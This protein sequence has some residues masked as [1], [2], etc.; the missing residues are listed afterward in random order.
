ME[1][2]RFARSL[3]ARKNGSCVRRQKWM[4]SLDFMALARWGHFSTGHH[5]ATFRASVH[6]ECDDI[7]TEVCIARIPPA[8][9]LDLHD[10]RSSPQK[11]STLSSGNPTRFCTTDVSSS[12]SSHQVPRVFAWRSQS[13]LSGQ[14][15]SAANFLF[16]EICVSFTMSLMLWCCEE[17]QSISH[18]G[19]LPLDAVASVV[20]WN[21]RLLELLN[22][23]SKF[24]TIIIA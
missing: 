14:T 4:L 17:L 24:S 6:I 22:S 11:G 1:R 13:T 10:S 20:R 9:S 2:T 12:G 18:L 23:R 15:S 3:T 5:L 7:E 21:R 8:P 16:V 19:A